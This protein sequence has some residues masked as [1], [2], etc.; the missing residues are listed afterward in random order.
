MLFCQEGGRVLQASVVLLVTCRV[1][2]D[3]G[4]FPLAAIYCLQT[5]E[6]DVWA[7]DETQTR[8]LHTADSRGSCSGLFKSRGESKAG[9][10]PPAGH[11]EHDT[12]HKNM[13][14]HNIMLTLVLSPRECIQQGRE[15]A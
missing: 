12:K 7:A 9:V 14:A 5:R 3:D 1:D 11:K 8:Y 2:L 4:L 15:Q 6:K 10:S 13:S